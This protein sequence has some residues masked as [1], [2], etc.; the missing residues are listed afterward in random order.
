M[1]S[2]TSNMPQNGLDHC[3]C[4]GIG[5]YSGFILFGLRL[6]VKP[7]Q[8]RCPDGLAMPRHWSSS[9]RSRP[10]REGMHARDL[11]EKHIGHGQNSS[12]K[13]R[14]MDYIGHLL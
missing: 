5:N 2:D 3:K 12:S 6:R 4:F 9:A 8:V 1:L 14:H 7:C 10:A 11:P 13:R